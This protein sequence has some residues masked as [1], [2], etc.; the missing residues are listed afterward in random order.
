MRGGLGCAP[1][2]WVRGDAMARSGL[3]DQSMGASSGETEDTVQIP[4]PQLDPGDPRQLVYHLLKGCGISFVLCSNAPVESTLQEA[5]RVAPILRESTHVKLGIQRLNRD[6]DTLWAALDSPAG[7]AIVVFATPDSDSDMLF[8]SVVQPFE[9]SRPPYHSEM[10]FSGSA[11]P[12]LARVVTSGDVAPVGVVPA[13]Q[14]LNEVDGFATL[15][16]YV[17]RAAAHWERVGTEIYARSFA[18][19]DA[20]E[21]E[22]F[23]GLVHPPGRPQLLLS[24][25]KVARDKVGALQ[26]LIAD[27][28]DTLEDLGD[29]NI[30][31]ARLL[32]AQ[33]DA[34]HLD[35]MAQ[36][37][38]R[39]FES[40]W[41]GLRA[42]SPTAPGN[43]TGASVW[44]RLEQAPAS[45]KLAR[46][47]AFPS[48]Q[49]TY[50]VA[51]RVRE[52]VPE[53]DSTFESVNLLG[54]KLLAL[55]GAGFEY[56]WRG[57]GDV[58]LSP[59]WLTFKAAAL[60]SESGR[61]VAA[62]H[63]THEY[64][65]LP[66]AHDLGAI[67]GRN[68]FSFSENGHAGGLLWPSDWL[69]VGSTRTGAI[70]PLDAS[71]NL[72][73]V[74]LHA[75]S[76]VTAALNFLGTS[77]GAVSVYDAAGAAR[78]LTVVEDLSGTESVRFSGDGSW[79]LVSRSKSATLVE[80]ASGRWLTLEVGN[81]AWWPLEAATLLTVV[82]ES[83][84]ATPQLFSL[85]DNIS[86]ATF[87]D[88]SLSVPMLESFPYM[89]SPTVAPDGTE[90]LVMTPAGVTSEYQRQHG[91]GNH[92]A[93]ISLKDGAGRLVQDV[94][95]DSEATLE[96]DV[97]D[98]RWTGRGLAAAVHLHPN[99][100]GQLN[101][102]VLE[103]EW[104]EP[105]R[106]AEE[107]DRMLSHALSRAVDLTKEG[108]DVSHLMPEILA[109]LK[110]IAVSPEIWGQRAES[111]ASLDQSTGNLIVTGELAGDL[112]TAWQRYRSAMAAI[113]D[114]RPELI[115]PVIAAWVP[116]PAPPVEPAPVHQAGI[117][118]PPPDL[119]TLP[120]A[121]ATQA[122]LRREP[123]NRLHRAVT[124]RALIAAALVVVVLLVVIG[125]QLSTRGDRSDAL[126]PQQPAS[127][128]AS[129]EAAPGQSETTPEESLEPSGGVITPDLRVPA[130]GNWIVVLESVPKDEHDLAYA[131]TL[132][133]SVQVRGG[134]AEV[135]DSDATP[136]LN[137][138]YWVVIKGD[139]AAR[140]DA[141]QECAGLGRDVGGDCYP[142]LVG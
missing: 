84:R 58:A 74:D 108:R 29:A 28:T 109:C 52:S 100:A 72:I 3:N 102:P 81:C 63:L 68:G 22:V 56:S 36:Q 2:E 79:L 78:L 129:E 76:G 103:H 128:A 137:P 99:L 61:F 42:A 17:R 85:R 114:G 59:S 37:L 83:G 141:A 49:I 136:G 96:R 44:E 15:P 66:P 121:Q 33:L 1:N 27:S 90:L 25:G 140:T 139:F 112:A 126:A 101:E 64:L 24:I 80:V 46:G 14:H 20:A 31:F 107:S 6:P 35:L 82:H 110:T 4:D 73:S 43:P 9:T 132:A 50:T 30:A 97:R 11:S 111:L 119:Q 142:R 53:E 34:A 122:P 75:S 105:G 40:R 130:K 47:T 51:E 41:K 7:S 77:V 113:R 38:V 123:D 55:R 57:D 45:A 71:V 5:A 115:D 98:V 8:K 138:G 117:A 118:S 124:G 86:T 135:I 60:D 67:D 125:M 89:W 104:L 69:Y 21:Q 13:L 65:D 120:R 18:A 106:W 91:A 94:F 48:S 39:D 116:A 133:E 87:D 93:R 12:G 92:L 70:A 134:T 127:T 62:G 54:G 95:F 32:P 88:L 10:V 131:L 23:V 26:P 16:A 19:E